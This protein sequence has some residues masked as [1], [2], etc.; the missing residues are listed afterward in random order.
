MQESKK[1]VAG[2]PKGTKS[3]V[4]APAIA[5]GKAVRARRIE[6]GLS[7]ED[8]ASTASVERSHMGKIERGEH[9]PNFVLILRL[10]IALNIP[11]GE[12]VDKAVSLIDEAY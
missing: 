2:R 6:V 3:F 12:L 8:L 7:Q 9:M 4:P 1:P 10:A 5:F 11:A